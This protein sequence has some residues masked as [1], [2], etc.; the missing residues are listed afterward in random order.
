MITIIISILLCFTGLFITILMIEMY[1]ISRLK[2]KID[3][4]LWKRKRAIEWRATKKYINKFKE[5]L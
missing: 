2:E 1:Q 4:Y 5:K 3:L